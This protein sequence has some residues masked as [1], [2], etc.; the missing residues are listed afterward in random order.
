LRTTALAQPVLTSTAMRRAIRPGAR[1]VRG[2]PFNTTLAPAKLLERVDSGEVTS[3]PPK[4]TPAG[5]PIVDQASQAARPSGAPQVVLDWLKRY[6]WLPYAVPVFAVVLAIVFLIIL[7]LAAGL[8]LAGVLV[9]G[10]IYVVPLLCRS[11]EAA[12]APPQHASRRLFPIRF[13]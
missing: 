9:A 8:V 12:I 1:L 6:P 5:V 3:A 7:G 11:S 2:L 4:T 13:T 10:T